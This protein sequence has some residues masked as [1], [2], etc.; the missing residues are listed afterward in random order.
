MRVPLLLLL[1]AGPVGALDVIYFHLWK[2]RLYARPQ[3]AREQTVH[4]VRGLFVPSIVAVLLMGRPE[5]ACFWLVAALFAADTIN[6]LIDVLLEPASR[7]PVGIPPAELALHFLGATMMGAAWATFM[8]EGWEFRAAPALLRAHKA[9]PQPLVLAA[10]AG[11]AAAFA[12]L[13]VETVLTLRARLRAGTAIPPGEL[14]IDQP[15]SRS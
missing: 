9:L 13:A 4:L 15:L 7:A 2:F 11:V 12:L 5:G 14:A 8:S 10:W 6:S 1:A 3:S